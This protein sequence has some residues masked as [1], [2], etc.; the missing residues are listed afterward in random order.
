MLMEFKKKLLFIERLNLHFFISL[1]IFILCSSVL[2]SQVPSQNT[3]IF[4]SKKFNISFYSKTPVEDI[5]AES[6]VVNA[7]LIKNTK[8]LVFQVNI[9]SFKF[10]ISLMEE[11]FNESYL[12]SNKFPVAKFKGVI[13]DSVNY[14]KDG[15]YPIKVQGVLTMHGV[16]KP[17]I[18]QGMIKIKN[19]QIGLESAFDVACVDHKIEIPRLLFAK[20]SEIIKV[21]VEGNF[22]NN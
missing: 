6:K 19:G 9:R 12:E 20:I 5:N 14:T 22:D 8:T 15:T 7:I 2:C 17:R 11:H 13:L 10:P 3:N 1:G 4:T 21:T 18:I 16:D